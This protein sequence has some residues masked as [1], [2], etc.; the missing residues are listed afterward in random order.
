MRPDCR[1]WRLRPRGLLVLLVLVPLLL[2]QGRRDGGLATHEL[3]LA[4]VVLVVTGLRVRAD[5]LRLLVDDR[6]VLLGPAGRSSAAVRVP[7]TSVRRVVLAPGTGRVGVLLVPGAPRPS[8]VRGT[9]SDPARPDALDPQLVRDVPGLDPAA[10][11]RAV[12]A[13]GV[14]VG[15]S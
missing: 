1:V 5:G 2:V 4:V 11:T 15:S 12:L 9:V 7:W 8:G 3:V 14:A 13:R 6:G 10:L